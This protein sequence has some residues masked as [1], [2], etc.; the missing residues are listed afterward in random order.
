MALMRRDRG[1]WPEL[2]RRFFDTDW[3][4]GWL[5]VE[6]FRDG[7]DLVVRADLPGI[8]P[9]KDVEL[10][11]A[12]GVLHIR[13]HREQKSEHKDKDTYRSEFQYGSFTRAI[14]LPAGADGSQ[15]KASYRDGVLEIRVPMPSEAKVEATKIPISRG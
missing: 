10:S 13:A 5:R 3:D 9:D 6:E 8:D 11:V 7:D 15:V 2:F 12:D 1:D 14:S 4:A